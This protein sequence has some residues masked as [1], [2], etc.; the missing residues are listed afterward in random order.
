M[1]AI[2]WRG[3]NK[4]HRPRSETSFQVRRGGEEVMDVKNSATQSRHALQQPMKALLIKLIS[5]AALLKSDI[6]Q[7][8]SS[9]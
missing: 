8:S 7:G 4:E 6:G 1:K 2:F 3:M 9:F 5:L